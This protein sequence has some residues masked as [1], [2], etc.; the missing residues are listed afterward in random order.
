MVN[1]LN[2]SQVWARTA[3][4]AAGN[5]KV[6][7]RQI[8]KL[9]VSSMPQAQGK[10]Y[11]A[12]LE[13][14]VSGQQ[15]M[16]IINGAGDHHMVGKGCEGPLKPDPGTSGNNPAGSQGATHTSHGSGMGPMIPN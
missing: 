11:K 13:K 7:G 8:S 15:H 4:Y 6:F 12:N 10:E 3:G 5:T 16:K 14:D 1:P 2:L 9:D